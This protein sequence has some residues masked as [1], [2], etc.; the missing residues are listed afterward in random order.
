MRERV[1]GLMMIGAV[2]GAM[3]LAG[4]ARAL[5][6]DAPVQRAGCA[7]K[8]VSGAG[9]QTTAYT[10]QTASALTFSLRGGRASDWDLAVFD[11]ATGRRLAGSGAW[12]ADEVAQ[13][14]A[15]RGQRLDVQACRI[16]GRARTLKLHLA[17]APLPKGASTTPVKESLVRVKTTSAAQIRRLASLGFDLGHDASATGISAVLRGPLERLALKKAGFEFVTVVD[18]LAAQDR[19]DR[20]ADRAYTAKMRQAGGSPLPTGRT[21]YRQLEDYYAEL[22]KLAQDHPAIVKPV[23]LPKKSFQGREQVGVEISSNVNATDDQKPVSFIMGLHHAREWPAAEVPMEFAHYLAKGYGTD[24]VITHFLNTTRVVIVPIINPDGFLASRTSFSIADSLD[25]TGLFTTVEALGLGGTLA[26]RRKNCRGASASP[27]TPCVLQYGVDPNRNYAV[28]WGGPGA[29]TDP[30]SQTYRGP[31]PWS[32]TETQSVHEFSQVRNVTTLLTIHNVAALVLR[33]PGTSTAGLAPDEPALKALGDAMGADTGYTSQYGYQLYDTSGTTEDWNYTAAGTY[34]YT[35][36][37]GPEN[38]DFH[39][40]YQVGVVD[41]WTGTGPRKGRGLRSALLRMVEAA[42]DAKQFSTIAGRAPAGRTLR[43]KREFKTSTA[44][45]CAIAQLLP[46]NLL[47]SIGGAT[48][49]INPGAPIVLDDKLEYTTKVPANGNFSWLVTPS[50][51]PFDHRAGK[52]TA[53]TLTCEDDGGKVLET[54]QV[55]IWRGETQNLTLSG[56]GKLVPLATAPRSKITRKSVRATRRGLQL[57]GTAVDAKRVEVAVGRRV[58]KRCRFLRANGAFTRARSCRSGTFLRANGTATWT[59]VV[60]RRLP[61]GRYVAWARAV[62]PGGKHE[63][64]RRPI[65]FRI[66]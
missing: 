41:E 6:I 42:T 49:C 19:V 63:R 44:P 58:G 31:S 26:Y 38:G 48:N 60:K 52:D 40:P 47:D 18:D 65:S 64:E 37:I 61:T 8:R 39:M 24:N 2:A 27:T 55:T 57:G 12:G 30:T 32:E 50:S 33:P 54:R 34:G 45:V 22:K 62:A 23:T 21:E 51:S 43:V 10:A 14:F 46:V 15:N 16:S 5:T 59:L 17:S 1:S 7:L 3:A 11:H 29:S 25:P 9:T 66:R 4:D 35:I 56:C 28:G 36:E 13:V 53:W 20:A